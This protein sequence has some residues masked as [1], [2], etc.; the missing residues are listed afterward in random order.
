MFQK[1]P[2]RN[3]GFTLPG[4]LTATPKHLKKKSRKILKS[5]LIIAVLT[6]F[7]FTVSAKSQ[8]KTAVPQTAVVSAASQTPTD[9][10]TQKRI[11][12]LIAQLGDKRHS[13]RQSAADALGKIGQPAVQ[14]LIEAISDKN[15]HVRGYA[16]DALGQIGDPQSVQP[17]IKA[18]EDED[19]GVR[20]S[21]I[22]AF[23]K[24]GDPQ[25]IQPLIKALSDRDYSVRGLAASA[26]GKIGQA[27]VEPL[28]KALS[29]RDSRVRISA[30]DILS[31]IGQPAVQFLIKAL[32]DEGISV[33]QSAARTLGQIGDPQAV[34]PL[35]K[36][37][38]DEEISVRQS[39]ADALGEIGDPQAVQP[40]IK[41]LEDEDVGV[42]QCAARTLGKIGNPQA[43]Q[44][45]IKALSDRNSRVRKSAANA[46]GKIDDPQ[47][48]RE[49][50]KRALVRKARE[51]LLV[52]IKLLVLCALVFLLIVGLVRLLKSQRHNIV[53][54]LKYIQYN[55]ETGRKSLWAV[56]IYLALV[57]GNAICPLKFYLLAL[58]LRHPFFGLLG[59]LGYL[60]LPIATGGFLVLVS[61]YDLGAP[62]GHLEM[63][64][65]LSLAYSAVF[66]LPLFGY[67]FFKKRN[68]KI[69]CALVQVVFIICHAVALYILIT[70]YDLLKRMRDLLR[71]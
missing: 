54:I 61:E 44:P 9:E 22:N 58:A 43:V 51:V 34:Q 62:Y 69:T 39:A 60:W 65:L 6:P 35:I 33:R 8:G 27:A 14:P 32:E 47:A 2:N 7:L 66:F 50:R 40:L 23:G 57:F 11:E 15:Y 3:V 37:L 20:V 5:L 29:D 25:A 71:P 70:R 26:L 55:T 64:Y 21:A 10:D 63:Y 46:L 67:L 42:R 31:Q 53:R 68:A 48:E 41:A 16:A 19:L 4:G 12:E 56:L 13:V 49:L 45:L 30:I 17:L 38:E 52:V 36:A 59:L 28:I 1:V 24:I 18:L